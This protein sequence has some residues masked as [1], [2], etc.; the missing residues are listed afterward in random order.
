MRGKKRTSRNDSY[1]KYNR[2]HNNENNNSNS[3]NVC[4]I[5]FLPAN[6]VCLHIKFSQ[7]LCEVGTTMISTLQMKRQSQ[8]G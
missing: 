3:Y 1:E 8:R 2:A 4:I 6:A 5:Y 7:Q